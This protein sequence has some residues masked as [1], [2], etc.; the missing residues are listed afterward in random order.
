MAA[1]SL[2][3]Y[4]RFCGAILAP[5]RGLTHL[6]ENAGASTF[7]FH[8]CMH[9]ST[10]RFRMTTIRQHEVSKN[11]F[12]T[13]KNFHFKKFPQ[14]AKGKMFEVC[15]ECEDWLSILKDM[16]LVFIFCAGKFWTKIL[17]DTITAWRDRSMC[18]CGWIQA[19][20]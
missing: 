1:P 8:V 12:L 19:V 3:S 2:K 20:H 14:N 7:V 18:G 17:W 6:W 11:N 9:A 4:W 15:V 16:L 5:S 10:K 13:R